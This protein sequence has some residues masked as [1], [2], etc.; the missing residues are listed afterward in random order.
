MLL[1]LLYNYPGWLV[2]SVIV[3]VPVV[4]VCALL[5]LFHRIIPHDSRLI[6]NEFTG[7]IIAVIGINY[8]VLIAFVAVAV[9]GSFD[10]ASALAD[11]EADLVGNMYQDAPGL[12][13]VAAGKLRIHLKEYAQVVLTEEWPA[14]A[15]GKYPTAGWRP[16]DEVQD[17]LAGYHAQ[18]GTQAVYLQEVLQ[19]L[20]KVYDARRGRL[21]ASTV[22]VAPVVWTIVLLGTCLTIAFTFL[23]GM[24][25]LRM[26]MVMT[27]GFTA[28]AMLVLV[29]IIA[30]DWPF[31]G[32]VQ[33]EPGMFLRA[34]AT[35]KR[36]DARPMPWSL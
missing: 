20:N 28:A 7:Y 5:K 36:L 24:P 21:G 15:K 10:K 1:D 17:L 4:L 35:M 30:L 33:V 14:M 13:P 25:S 11:R 16:L 12:G 32:E 9:W 27:G 23:F 8:A 19:S 26:H 31:R 3:I 2:G 6:H 18:S 29:L 34:Q 22:G